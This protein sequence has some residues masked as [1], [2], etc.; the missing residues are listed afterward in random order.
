MPND[1]VNIGEARRDEKLGAMTVS[2][3]PLP[4]PSTVREL[5]ASA[6]RCAHPDC[7][8]PLYKVSDENGD[9]VLNS[10]V[11]HIHA[12]R[13]GGPRWVD[14]PAEE[15]R[16]F[17]N[18]I[19]LCIEHSYEVDENPDPY[20]ADLLREWKARQVAEYEQI[21]RNWPINDD[22]A[23]EVLVASESLDTL[24]AAST[25]ELVRRVEALRL[26]AERTRSGVRAWAGR[27]QQLRERTRSSYNMWDEDGNPVYLEPSV[28]EARPM[29]E[30]ISNALADALKEI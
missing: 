12:R 26:A 25:V 20:P 28:A 29:R 19:L 24:H 21:R 11:A 7:N 18:L 5:Y 13:K 4:K 2:A 15:N 27:W 10:R 14:M 8:R 1:V 17:D 23:T 6:F 3:Y 30:G 22:E 16:A 9:R